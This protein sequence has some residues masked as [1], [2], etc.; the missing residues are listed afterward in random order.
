MLQ[1]TLVAVGDRGR[2]PLPPPRGRVA[3]LPVIAALMVVWF[4]SL[5]LLRIIPEYHWHPLRHIA[6]SALSG[7]RRSVRP[8]RRGSARWSP[9]PRGASGRGRRPPAGRGPG[10]VGADDA[11]ARAGAGGHRPGRRLRRGLRGRAARAPASPRRAAGA[12]SRS[13]SERARRRDLAVPV[14]RPAGR[15]AAGE[16]APA[17]LVRGRRPRAARRSRTCA[18]TSRRRPAETRGRDG[19]GEDGGRAAAAP[20]ARGGLE[21][22]RLITIRSGSIVTSTCRWPAQCSE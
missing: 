2:L 5:F 16:D 20:R 10:P 3:Q 9:R 6:L 21:A 19:G 14:L 17:A 8:A 1:A 13:P 15:G 7:A 18:T 11:D 4:A 22:T 12:A